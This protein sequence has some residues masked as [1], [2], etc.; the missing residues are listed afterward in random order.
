MTLRPS[1]HSPTH[2]NLVPGYC[3][4][5]QRRSSRAACSTAA[6]A[7][8]QSTSPPAKSGFAN[9]IVKVQFVGDIRPSA[10]GKVPHTGDVLTFE[11][12][13][14]FKGEGQNGVDTTKY[15]YPGDFELTEINGQQVLVV[16]HFRDL[17]SDAWNRNEVYF[18]IT[19]KTLE[20]NSWFTELPGSLS[21]PNI[22][23][24]YQIALNKTGRAL[25]CSFYGNAVMLLEVTPGV[26][27]REIKRIE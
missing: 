1:G 19:A 13:S 26:G 23:T 8:C 24:Y 21:S 7:S 10:E 4:P 20:E 3:L 12:I 27:I 11:R 16:N 25:S 6:T 18:S 9:Q 14:G 5:A 2:L 15:H 22:T 17:A